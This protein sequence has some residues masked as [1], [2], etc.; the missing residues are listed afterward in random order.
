MT[1]RTQATLLLPLLLLAASLA[2][3]RREQRPPGPRQVPSTPLK[4]IYA[5]DTAGALDPCG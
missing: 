5:A 3:C 1:R 4:I 2:D